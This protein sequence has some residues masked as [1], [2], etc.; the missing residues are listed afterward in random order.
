[1]DSLPP[2]DSLRSPISGQIITQ[3]NKVR[4]EYSIM[5][6]FPV[7]YRLCTFTNFVSL[8]VQ[9]LAMQQPNLF[10]RFLY[11]LPLPLGESVIQT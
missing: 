1:M 4:E 3:V 10:L 9:I 7:R 2:Y 6:C 8:T 11:P 5:Q